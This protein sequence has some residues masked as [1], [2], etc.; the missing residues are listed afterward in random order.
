MSKQM[1]VFMCCIFLIFATTTLS[2]PASAAQIS[3]ELKKWHKVTLTF[4]GPETS[5]AANP[6]AYRAVQIHGGTGY[7]ND[8]RV[9]QL[10]RDARITTIYEG[11]SEIQRLVI[12]REA[13]RD[14]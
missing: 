6:I 5:E 4:D 1:K 12:A 9:E 8:C 11:T 10:Y 3:G 7:V 2:R 13:L 14:R